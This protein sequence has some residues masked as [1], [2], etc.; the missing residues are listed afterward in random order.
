MNQKFYSTKISY[1]KEIFQYAYIYIF[2]C[3]IYV[4]DISDEVKGNIVQPKTYNNYS[5]ISN[6]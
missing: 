4:N 1:M 2:I 5:H 6:F 3:I